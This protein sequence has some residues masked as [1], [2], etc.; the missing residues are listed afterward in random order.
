LDIL[1]GMLKI[2]STSPTAGD[3]STVAKDAAGILIGAI[4]SA[5]VVPDYYSQVAAHAI[6]TSQTAPF[7]GKY[8]DVLKSAFVRR[9]ILSLQ[10][11]ATISSV[12]VRNLPKAAMVAG[13]DRQ[14]AELPK[15]SISAAG[16]GLSR[17]ALTVHTAED[18]KQFAITSASLTLGAVEAALRAKTPR[19][20]SRKIFS[21]GDASKWA[22]THTRRQARFIPWLSERMSSLRRKATWC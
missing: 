8:K 13:K 20:R 3:L 18:A 7:D 17:A 10:A 11:A 15:A 4:L 19:N 21:S 22:P 14:P 5:P 16:Y 6:T 9:G 12:Q 1:A 2:Q